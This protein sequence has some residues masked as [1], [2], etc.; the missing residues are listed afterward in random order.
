M[1]NLEPKTK[2]D[3]GESASTAGFGRTDP[4][5]FMAVASKPHAQLA[6]EMADEIKAVVYAYEQRIPLA[7]AIGVLRI[8]EKEILDAA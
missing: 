8:V 5:R 2:P 6:G 3:G 7:L 4:R 1:S